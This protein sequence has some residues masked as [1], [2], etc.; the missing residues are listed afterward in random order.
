M[1]ID[2]GLAAFSSIRSQFLFSTVWGPLYVGGIPER[3][4]SILNGMS[5]TSFTGCLKELKIQQRLATLL[6]N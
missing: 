3:L 4:S 5:D 6:S 2:E 1:Y